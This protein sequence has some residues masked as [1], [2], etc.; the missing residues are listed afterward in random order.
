M[1]LKRYKTLSQVHGN[2]AIKYFIRLMVLPTCSSSIFHKSV[3]LQQKHE[4]KDAKSW[5]EEDRLP[6]DLR[7]NTVA[8]SLVF[9]SFSHISQVG[10]WASNSGP[11]AGTEFLQAPGKSCFCVFMFNK[12]LIL[13][14]YQQEHRSQLFTSHLK[15][16]YK[17]CFCLDQWFPN[18][19]F[20]YNLPKDWLE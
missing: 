15:N 4:E 13:R 20:I 14:R 11:P 19:S 12:L 16:N 2:L 9:L 3:C 18:S 7:N 1:R 10:H 5:K 8:S 6:G 17:V